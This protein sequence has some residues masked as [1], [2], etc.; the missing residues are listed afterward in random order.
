M[1]V[2]ARIAR[3]VG[4]DLSLRCFPA[5]G[6]LRDAAHVALVGRFLARVHPRIGRTIEAP[7]PMDRDQRGWDVL[8]AIGDT[9]VGVAAETRL[10]DLQALLRREQAKQRDGAVDQLLLVVADTRAN[11]HALHEAR[12]VLEAQGFAGTRLTMARL[13]RGEVPPQSGYAL[14]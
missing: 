5:G 13:E 8:L 12:V 4:L 10:R 11:R 7:I 9:Q 6:R 2:A 14:V 3:I 1:V